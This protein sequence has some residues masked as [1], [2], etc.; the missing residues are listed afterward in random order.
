MMNDLTTREHEVLN[1]VTE[2]RTNKE[3]ARMLSVTERTVEQHLTHIY[4]KL[5]VSSRSAA[6]I[7][8]LRSSRQVG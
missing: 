2:G 5:G 7:Y 6:L 8:V 4:R 1:L 3:I